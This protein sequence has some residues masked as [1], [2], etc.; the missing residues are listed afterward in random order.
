MRKNDQLR[1]DSATIFAVCAVVIGAFLLVKL[2]EQLIGVV[3]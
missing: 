1:N 3:A 2:I